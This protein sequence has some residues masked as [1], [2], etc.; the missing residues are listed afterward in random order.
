MN[1]FR[2]GCLLRDGDGARECFFVL[3]GCTDE[4]GEKWMRFERFRFEFRMELAAEKP[5]VLGRFD[6]FDVIFVGRA[7]RDS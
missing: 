1:F 6:D 4:C 5:R 3:D 2:N 7:A